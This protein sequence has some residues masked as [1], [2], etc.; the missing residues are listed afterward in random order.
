[1][2]SLL[3]AVTGDRL[4]A[5]VMRSSVWILFGYGASQAIRLGANLILTRLL[6]PEAFGMMALVMVLM[7]GLVMFSDVGIGPSIMQ[8]KRGDDPDFLDTAWTIQIL[9]GI[10]LWLACWALAAPV[11]RFYGEP[12]LADL[13]PV[14]GLSLLIGGF[15]PTRLE[16]ANRH[17]MIG[18]VTLI[19]LCTQVVSIGAM[20]LLAWW[21]RSEWALVIG[22]VFGAALK[23]A[24]LW[25]LLPGT[26]N[27]LLWD[28]DA[29]RELIRFGKWIFL[30]TVCGFL[31]AQGDKA[32]LG[33]YVSLSSLGI[34]N[35]GYFLAS[36]P[37]FLGG[38]LAGRILIPLYRELPPGA[39]PEN[40]LKI[41]KM[42]LALTGAILTLVLAMAFVGVP[43]I[44]FLYDPRFAA[45]GAILVALSCALIPQ[46]IV[47]TYDQAALAAGD[48]R[49]FFYLMA[50]RATAHLACLLI[51]VETAGLMGAVAGQGLALVLTYP[52]IVWL[53]RRH[54]AWDPLHDASYGLLGAV[55]A[56]LSL[57][58]N[59]DAFRLLADIG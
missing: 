15:N 44:G 30:S 57:W 16:T 5:R 48:S 6:F 49:N 8:S 55:L 29:S 7:T 45:A 27:R 26:P 1:M 52:M 40:Y 37:L 24:F 54:G 25:A 50:V 32:I 38:A 59:W 9:R 13:L 23:L 56:G 39:G 20:V 4:A 47:L 3:S 35:V 10:G 2:T 12:M 58:V 51:G 43:L 33:K 18:R 36:F 21:L 17:L 14:A 22:I 41:R 42:R 11:A 19:D 34:Y 46:I 31:V 53:A 28:R